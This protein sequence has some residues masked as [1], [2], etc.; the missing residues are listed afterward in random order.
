[1]T[2]LALTDHGNLYGAFEFYE[3][4]TAAGIK[5]II[6]YEAYV[7]PGSR[8]HK[9]ASSMKEASFHLTLLARD[10][11]GFQNLLKLSSAAFL[12]GFY[13]RPRIDKPLLEAH[14][15][16]LI[17]LSGCIS[18]E[19]NRALIA[20]EQPDFEKAVQ[21]VDWFRRVFG[22]RYYIEIQNNGMELQRRATEYAAEIARRTGV[23]LVAT[24]DVHYVER[25]DAVA[26]DIL[27]CIN[28]GKFRTDQNRMRLETN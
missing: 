14:H 17:C 10:R 27:L 1:M 13:F 19:L 12:E 16:G 25:D 5:P 2:A 6:G 8:F 28:T 23:P 9:D 3:K 18:S 15:E 24:S 22:D 21:V 26:Q 4:A 20:G 11:T 7:A